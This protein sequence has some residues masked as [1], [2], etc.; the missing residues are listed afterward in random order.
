M[1]LVL[2]ICGTICVVAGFFLPWLYTDTVVISGYRL[3]QAGYFFLFLLPLPVLFSAY[4]IVKNPGS[5][6]LPQMSAGSA[7]IFLILL[8]ISMVLNTD[9]G[10]LFFRQ[11]EHTASDGQIEGLQE[12]RRK[13][14]QSLGLCRERR[15]GRHLGIERRAAFRDFRAKH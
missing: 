15:R 10:P 4:W 11:L 7:A 8:L 3:A 1:D 13:H 14:S 6:P 2:T 12:V 9:S 5:R